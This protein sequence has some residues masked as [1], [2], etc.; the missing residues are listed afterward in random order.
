MAASMTRSSHAQTNTQSRALALGLIALLTASAQVSHA[1]EPVPD[2][3]WVCTSVLTGP[4]DV[5]PDCLIRFCALYE[6]PTATVQWLVVNEGNVPFVLC[7]A[8]ADLTTAHV[9]LYSGGLPQN[10]AVALPNSALPLGS[11]GAFVA[12]AS[13]SP[14]LVVT[15]F[16][17]DVCS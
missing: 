10:N 1:V 13:E 3:P 16:E 14:D 12:G 5:C 15:S 8:Q 7:S 11:T 4:P 6:A 17:L 9:V 2:P